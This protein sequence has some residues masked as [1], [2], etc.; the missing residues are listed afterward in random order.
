MCAF[1]LNQYRALHEQGHK[2]ATRGTR[3]TDRPELQTVLLSTQ[4]LLAIQSGRKVAFVSLLFFMKRF[5]LAL[6]EE[7]GLHH[8]VIIT[9]TGVSLFCKMT[10]KAIVKKTSNIASSLIPMATAFVSFIRLA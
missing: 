6:K 2:R 5:A 1:V 9:I 8:T 3:V 4:Q 7:H 10:I